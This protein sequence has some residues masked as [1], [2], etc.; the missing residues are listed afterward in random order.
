MMYSPQFDEMDVPKT[1][2]TAALLIGGASTSALIPWNTCGIFMSE[3][4]GVS[5]PAYAPYAF[6]NWIM[7]F[8]YMVYLLKSKKIRS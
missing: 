1:E 3:V 7:P 4:L 8:G 5:V 2:L 6:F